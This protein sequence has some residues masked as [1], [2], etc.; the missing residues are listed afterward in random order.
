VEQEARFA[1]DAWADD[2]GA[3]AADKDEVSVVAILEHVRPQSAAA[4]MNGSP[5]AQ[6]RGAEAGAHCAE[7]RSAKW[8]SGTANRL[9]SLGMSSLTV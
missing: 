5:P 6:K 2:V 7:S 9:G 3:Y 8:D 1:E 4:E